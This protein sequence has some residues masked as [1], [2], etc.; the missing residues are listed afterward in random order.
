MSI[1][2]CVVSNAAPERAPQG[3]LISATWNGPDIDVRRRLGELYGCDTETWRLLAQQRFRS[4]PSPL[5]SREVAKGHWELG[6]A[7]GHVAS[8]RMGEDLADR[9]A[10]RHLGVRAF[11]PLRREMRRRSQWEQAAMSGGLADYN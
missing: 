8:I 2:T 1:H 9:L 4:A 6:R 7:F 10:A 11:G 5:S 3:A